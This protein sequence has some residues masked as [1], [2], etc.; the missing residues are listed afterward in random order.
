MGTFVRNETRFRPPQVA[1]RKV[2]NKIVLPSYNHSLVFIGSDRMAQLNWRY[3][4]RRGSTNI[5][6]F[7]LEKS[8]GEIFVDLS[9]ARQEAKEK[10]ESFK[11]Y[12]LYLFIHALLHLKG[13]NHIHARPRARMEREE[14]KWL[15]I[16][17]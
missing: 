10:S 11:N 7:P 2:K 17:Q 3:R 15:R 16:F 5:L 6:A 12:V 4:K 14:K 8:S 9:L 13:F 1:W